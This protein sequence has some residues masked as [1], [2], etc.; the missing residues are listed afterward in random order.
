MV[1]S[2]WN[3]NTRCAWKT[4][5]VG[6]LGWENNT[7][8]SLGCSDTIRE[9]NEYA[10]SSAGWVPHFVQHRAV[11]ITVNRRRHRSPTSDWLTL[12]TPPPPRPPPRPHGL[13]NKFAAISI[14]RNGQKVRLIRWVESVLAESQLKFHSRTSSLLGMWII[15]RVVS[16]NFQCE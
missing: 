14:C 16:R 6:L 1:G 5:L 7:V 4:R 15:D 10:G 8:M 2:P 9:C 13:T 12:S 3:F 11:I